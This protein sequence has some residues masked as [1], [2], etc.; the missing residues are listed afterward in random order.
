[1]NCVCGHDQ[2]FHWRGEGGCQS[3][4]ITS[5]GCSEYLPDYADEGEWYYAS[6]SPYWGPGG[7]MK[8]CMH[9]FPERDTACS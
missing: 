6:K 5:C 9:V 2:G 8:D 1:M 4:G 7:Q 3:R